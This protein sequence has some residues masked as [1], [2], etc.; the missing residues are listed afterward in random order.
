MCNRKFFN[1]EPEEAFA[2]FNYLA[3]NVQSWDTF[4]YNK[5]EP[6]KTVNG[7]GGNYTLNEGMICKINL[8]YCQKN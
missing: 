1:K 2:Y 3:K 4:V 8:P 7:W 5:A 6:L